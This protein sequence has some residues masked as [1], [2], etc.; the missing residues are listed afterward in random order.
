MRDILVRAR[1]ILIKF[2]EGLLVLFTV[3]LVFDVVWQ[4]IARYLL[5]APPSWTEELANMLLVWVALLGA[6]LAFVRH[7]HLGV[8]ILVN[9][10]NDHH[11]TV[12]DL[13]TY[14]LIAFF[15]LS[16]LIYGGSMLVLGTF[17]NRQISPAL[18]IPRGY[19]YS[20]LPLSGFFI[21]M[22]S[23]GEAVEKVASLLKR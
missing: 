8:D 6:S 9:K 5:N 23:V 18:Q 11:R 22:F 4:V 14:S 2:L 21:F 10:L 7:S 19:A 16:I 13:V 17:E 1:R 12:A 20:I 3:V 15:A